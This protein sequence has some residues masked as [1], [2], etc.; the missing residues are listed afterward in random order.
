M[1][2]PPRRE[3]RPLRVRVSFE[4]TRL[5]AEQVAAAYDQVLPS[6]NRRPRVPVP[7]AH[8]PAQPAQARREEEHA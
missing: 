7:K 2:D 6:L 8:P 1:Q 5:A 3:P 4:P